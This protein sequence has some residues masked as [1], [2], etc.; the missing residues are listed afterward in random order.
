MGDEG[1]E[2]KKSAKKEIEACAICLPEEKGFLM[3]MQLTLTPLL[4]SLTVLFLKRRY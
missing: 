4:F 2:R 3:R 1:S